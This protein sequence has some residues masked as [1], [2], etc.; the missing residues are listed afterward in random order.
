MTC[1]LPQ[2]ILKAVNDNAVTTKSLRKVQENITVFR[3]FEAIDGFVTG[4]VSFKWHSIFFCP[5]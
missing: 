5:E 2:A 1:I 3:V 4:Y